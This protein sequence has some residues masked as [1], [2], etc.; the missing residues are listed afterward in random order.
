MDAKTRPSLLIR[1]RDASDD[2][3]WEEFY[4]LYSPLVMAFCVS[5]GCR[6]DLAED[7]VQETMVCLLKQMPA[8]EYDPERG[9][10]RSFLCAVVAGRMKAAYKRETRYRRLDPANPEHAE[11]M[12]DEV[13]GKMTRDWDQLW[14]RLFLTEALEQVKG[15]IEPLTFRSFWM[16][17]VEDQKPE[18]VQ[19][20][21]GIKSRNTVYQQRNR[22]IALIRQ[23]LVDMDEAPAAEDA[24]CNGIRTAQ[25][26]R[27][28]VSYCPSAELK[29]RLDKVRQILKRSHPP[30][31]PGDYL[32]VRGGQREEWVPLQDK[33]TVGADPACDIQINSDYVSAKHCRIEGDSGAWVVHDLGSKNGVYVNA[34]RVTEPRPLRDGDVIELGNVTLVFLTNAEA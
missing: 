23:E 10:F 6:H 7:V 27:T 1:V 20:A 8:F 14:A 31:A 34:E 5:R 25:E 4:R 30:D 15:R 17:A 21:L 11:L 26:D 28:T 19:Q 12:Q 3:A 18:V 13:S 2:A 29:N 33:V 16:Y 24:I 9:Q 22:V 32:L